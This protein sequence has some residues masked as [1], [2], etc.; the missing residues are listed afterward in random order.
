MAT[1]TKA[2]D[3]GAITYGMNDHRS[4]G[5]AYNTGPH[6]QA[7][8]QSYVPPSQRHDG[9][10]LVPADVEVLIVLTHYFGSLCG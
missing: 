8:R 10:L 4:L 2:M 5:V 6:G 3:Y 9:L 1:N 7:S